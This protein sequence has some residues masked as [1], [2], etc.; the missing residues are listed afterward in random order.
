MA[1]SD[2]EQAELKRLEDWE[3]TRQRSTFDPNEPTAGQKLGALAYGGVTGL[4]GSLGEL[5]KFGAYD[6]PEYLGFREEGQPKD[7]LFGRETIFPTIKEA[8]KGLGYLGIKEPGEELSTPKEVGEFV[9]GMLPVSPSAAKGTAKALLGT[10]SKTGEAIAKKAESLGFKLSPA[11]VRADVPTPAKGATF[12][13]AKNQSLANKL[14]SASTGKEASEISEGFIR[15]RLKTLGGEFDKLYKG[16]TF[17]IDPD[18]VQAI[19]NIRAAEAASP[20]IAGTSAVSRTADDII[21]NFRNLASGPGAKPNTFGI[22]GEGLQR[23]RTALLERARATTS[24]S[25]AH[26]IYNLIDVIDASVAKNHPEVAAKLNVLRPQYRNTIILEDL[27]RRGGIKQGNISLSQ[28]GDMLRGKRDALRRTGNDI[29][30]LGQLGR[31][32]QLRARWET[33]G[34]AA[35]PG[36]DVVGKLLGTGTDL[37]STVTGLRSRPARAVQRFYASKPEEVTR[38][39]FGTATAPKA[40]AAG[41]LSRPLQQ[42]EE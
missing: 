38:L 31:E 32:L 4:A 19:E 7:T 20:G 16:K 37:A 24:R 11:Q 25:D 12:N 2:Q 39:G 15:G 8:R 1:L 21:A 36:Q 23:L 3:K 30:E 33:E 26:E 18:A 40:V 29:D 22:T 6:V 13:A 42:D 27:Q 9:G 14:A 10:P 17:R 28:L 5:E 35:L 41:T 34:K